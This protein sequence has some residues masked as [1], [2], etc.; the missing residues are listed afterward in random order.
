MGNGSNVPASSPAHTR[1]TLKFPDIDIK[2]TWARKTG[3]NVDSETRRWHEG[4]EINREE[5][6]GG[7]TTTEDITVSRNYRWDR[8]AEVLRWAIRNSGKVYGTI[9]EQDI[10]N[11]G[12]PAGSPFVRE[13]LLK[14]NNGKDVDADDRT[15]FQTLDLVLSVSGEVT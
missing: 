9:I 5:V 10:D 3:G 14:G 2:G 12:D 6:A 15:G 11:F 8:D 7:P 13:C 4:G 1:V